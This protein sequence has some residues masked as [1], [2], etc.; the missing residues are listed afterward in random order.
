MNEAVS[1]WFVYAQYDLRTI[2]LVMADD[3]FGVACFHAQQC[4]EKSLKAA[5]IL[6]EKK[7]ILT[8][9]RHPER[10]DSERAFETAKM[11]FDRAMKL[12][13]EADK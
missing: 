10:D 1:S 6:S 7:V 3:L 12:A 11:V 13:Q 2:P 9:Y 8:H 5:L 4:V